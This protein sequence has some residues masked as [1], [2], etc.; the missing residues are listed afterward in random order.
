[1]ADSGWKILKGNDVQKS[2]LSVVIERV[3]RRV[4]HTSVADE[5]ADTATIARR[6]TESITH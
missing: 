4:W 3:A 6:H 1:M 5:C 2:I